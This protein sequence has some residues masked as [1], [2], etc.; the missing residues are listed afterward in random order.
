MKSTQRKLIFPL[1]KG[2][3]LT[4][5]PGT[6]DA[7]AL[8][9]AKNTILRN[10]P[11]LRKR[12]GLRRI[13]YQGDEG[14]VQGATHWFATYG[15]APK[16]EIVRVR[17]GR[18]EVLREVG[19]NK[20]FVDLGVQVSDT[21]RVT[22]ERFTNVLIIHFQNSPP[23]YYTMG[24]TVSDMPILSS[25]VDSPPTFSRT[26]DFRLWYGGRG[27]NPHRLWVSATGNPFD[28]T[29][30]DG[31]FA[32][33]VYEG[34]GDPVGL[35]GLSPSFRGSLYAYKWLSTYEIALTAYGYSIAPVTNNAGAVCHNAITS[36]QQDVYSVDVNA[37]RS[38]AVT[39]N[40]GTEEPYALTAP[41]YEWF[42]DEVNWSAANQ[43]VLTYDHKSNCLLMS[44]VSS[45]SGVSNR[46][47]GMNVITKQFFYWDDCEYPAM[48]RYVEYGRPYTFVSDEEKGLC[49]LD[50]D[51]NTLDGD[52][53]NMDLQFGIIFPAGDPKARVNLTQGWLLAKPTL[54]D[55][56]VEVS[57]CLDAAQE[58]TVEVS[59][60][61]DAYG[62]I[63]GASLVGDGIIGKI[64][65]DLIAIPFSCVGE[66]GSVSFH[67]KQTPPEEDADQSCE[68]YGILYEMAVEEDSEK[69]VSR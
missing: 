38:L 1:G 62:A 33:A 68:I 66:C 10:R 5:I 41:I 9:S 18:I 58:T 19:V 22:F 57:Y 45:G 53:I 24:G 4:S 50:L 17:K 16:D 37:I 40:Y 2:M 8:K 47:L 48:G 39:K 64:A 3:D 54:K 35:T 13:P 63:I 6:Q 43:I 23:L 27:V 30:Y 61:G 56:K 20:V 46:V 51:E 65:D 26:H 59:T 21:D 29:L 42:Q 69:P 36:T 25:H 52:P 67:V 11:S 32:M 49:I 28:Y 55:V 44:Y 12:P 31:G 34:D 15:N 60:Q 7:A 14:G